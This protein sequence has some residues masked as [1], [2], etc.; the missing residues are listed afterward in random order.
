MIEM[1]NPGGDVF[2]EMLSSFRQTDAAMTSL[3]QGDA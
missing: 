2:E 1:L 3:E